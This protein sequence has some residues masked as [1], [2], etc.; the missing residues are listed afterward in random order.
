MSRISPIP[1]L[2]RHSRRPRASCFI[3]QVIDLD[4]VETLVGTER[5][6]SKGS[7]G[8]S[9][10]ASCQ[11]E[12]RGPPSWQVFA[13]HGVGTSHTLQSKAQVAGSLSSSF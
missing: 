12:D 9:C 2:P 6:E 5:L 13:G 10:L 7:L 1:E 3:L 11:R 4:Q 8:P